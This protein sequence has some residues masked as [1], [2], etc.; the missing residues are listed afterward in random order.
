MT[1]KEFNENY[2]IDVL[3]EATQPASLFEGTAVYPAIQYEAVDEVLD[4]ISFTVY[5]KG[6]N[7]MELYVEGGDEQRLKEALTET[8]GVIF[9]SNEEE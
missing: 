8:F 2:R 4:T 5:D 1:P 7:E 3:T 6:T 9:P